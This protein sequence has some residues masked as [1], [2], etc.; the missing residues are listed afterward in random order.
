M[1]NSAIETPETLVGDATKAAVVPP[2]GIAI[3]I[4]KRRQRLGDLI[5]GTVVLPARLTLM[6]LAASC[7]VAAMAAADRPHRS[8]PDVIHADAVVTAD[9]G[10]KVLDLTREDFHVEEDGETVEIVAFESS[11]THYRIGFHPIAGKPLAKSRKVRVSVKRKGLKV[12]SL[13]A[14]SLKAERGRAAQRDAE[15]PR[16]V[17]R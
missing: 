2:A 12:Q 15:H 17:G 16:P 13:K 14:Y 1:E 9:G 5:A 7:G 4:S 11:A 10:R 3:L 6:V 8:E